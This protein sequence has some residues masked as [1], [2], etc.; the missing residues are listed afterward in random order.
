VVEQTGRVPDRHPNHRASASLPAVLRRTTVPPAA[1]DWAWRATGQQVVGWRRLPGAS[2]SAVHALRLADGGAVVLRRWTWRYVLEEE[3]GIAARELD[4]L[5]LAAT[6]GLP[7]PRV[8][9]ADV[10]GTQV[11]DGVPALLMSRLPGR[12]VAVP[13][14][15]RLAALAAAVHEVDAAG[16]GHR[17]FRWSMGEL[18]GPPPAAGRPALWERALAVRR[19]AM[20]AHEDRFIHRD[21]HPGNVLW[22]RGRA[23]GL[24]DWPNACVGP[25]ECDVATCRLNLIRL[26]GMAAADAFLRAYLAMTGRAYHPYWDL[27]Y[28]LEQDADHWAPEEVADAEPLLARYL[29]ELG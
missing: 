2:S 4:A 7:A 23:T 12:A 18:T 28:L 15:G 22:S 20:P 14:L 3:P 10:D 5:T 16:F 17:F 24:V 26:S 19:D 8:V 1:R 21:Y 6:A 27:N 9:A 25:W 29:A 11:G 13:D